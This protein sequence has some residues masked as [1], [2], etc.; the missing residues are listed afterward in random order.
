MS[1]VTFDQVIE[2]V[3]D[4]EYI[5]DDEFNEL[6]IEDKVEVFCNVKSV[7]RI[8]FYNAGNVGLKPSLIITMHNFEYNGEKQII[9][10]GNKFEV[11]KTYMSGDLI[12]L[13]VGDKIGT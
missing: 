11:L 12:E 6:A 1:K 3:G 4:V 10:D 9:F 5:M 7:N 2:L 8:D 13:M